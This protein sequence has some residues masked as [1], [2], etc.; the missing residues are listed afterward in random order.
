MRTTSDSNTTSR[1]LIKTYNLLAHEVMLS[2]FDVHQSF[3]IS[4]QVFLSLI[5]S[6]NVPPRL[7]FCYP[8][9]ALHV[10]VNHVANADSRNDF[11]EVWQDATIEP[12]E[13]IFGYNRPQQR[14]H[15]GLV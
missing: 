7:S 13:T 1:Q 11:H 8:Q 6:E 15:G 4:F 9:S 5:N 3:W 12:K 10:L 14:T 2:M